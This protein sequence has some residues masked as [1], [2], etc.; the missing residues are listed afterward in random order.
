M[1]LNEN[2]LIINIVIYIVTKLKEN[3]NSFF[4]IKWLQM[5]NTLFIILKQYYFFQILWNK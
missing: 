3:N 5:Y 4:I 2:K 1:Y